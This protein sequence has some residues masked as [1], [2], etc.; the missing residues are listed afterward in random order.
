MID[1]CALYPHQA[2]PVEGTPYYELSQRWPN[3]ACHD[4]FNVL[5][6]THSEDETNFI[7]LEDVFL[8][9]QGEPLNLY[10]QKDY[11][12]AAW[13]LARI[14]VNPD[15]PALYAPLSVFSRMFAHPSYK[16]YCNGYEDETLFRADIDYVSGM[17]ERA[18]MTEALEQWKAATEN[19]THGESQDIMVSLIRSFS[20][21]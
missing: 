16:L 5:F 4:G 15:R 1:T 13:I 6:R 19:M 2:N 8:N 12:R 14:M 3:A 9:D 11:D 10:I 7:R 17:I 20:G 21:L 18:G